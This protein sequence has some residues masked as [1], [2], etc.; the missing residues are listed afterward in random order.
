MERPNVSA[1]EEEP[2]EKQSIV[3]QAVGEDEKCEAEKC[4]AAEPPKKKGWAIDKT[5]STAQE[6]KPGEPTN[7]SD[8]D[9]IGQLQMTDD[10]EQPPLPEQDWPSLGGPA[11]RQPKRT[12]R[13]KKR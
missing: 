13:G 12:W 6:G 8:R 10:P 2:V 11:A 9:Y 1:E 4:E 3:A 5:P 7:G